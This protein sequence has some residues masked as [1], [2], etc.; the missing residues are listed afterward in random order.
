ML[1]D[2]DTILMSEDEKKFIA[3]E[4]A[5]YFSIGFELLGAVL[6]LLTALFVVSDRRKAEEAEKI[7]AKNH[8]PM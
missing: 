7:E 4:R 5:M 2:N 3:L 8:I 6:F 1:T